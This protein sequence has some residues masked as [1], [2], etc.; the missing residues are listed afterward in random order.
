MPK[1]DN[2]DLKKIQVDFNFSSILGKYLQTKL[3]KTW[4]IKKLK[5]ISNYISYLCM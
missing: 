5:H 2:Y 1:A 4:H 3:M